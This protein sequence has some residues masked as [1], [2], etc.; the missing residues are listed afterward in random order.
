M[1]K[2]IYQSSLKSRNNFFQ[3]LPVCFIICYFN[4]SFWASWWKLFRIAQIKWILKRFGNLK[5]FCSAL[6]YNE[7]WIQSISKFYFCVIY[8]FEPEYFPQWHPNKSV[9]TLKDIFYLRRFTDLVFKMHSENLFKSMLQQITFK[10]SLILF[11]FFH[12]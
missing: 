8:V 11:Y 2:F 10:F 1:E 9:E 12:F 7:G 5:I 6:L 3:I 4:K